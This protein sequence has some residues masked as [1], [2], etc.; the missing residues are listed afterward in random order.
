VKYPMQL[1]RDAIFADPDLSSTVDG[2]SLGAATVYQGRDDNR[3]YCEFAVQTE[4][5]F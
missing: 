3:V 4:E 2:S 1:L 5:V